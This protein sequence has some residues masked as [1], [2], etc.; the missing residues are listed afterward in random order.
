VPKKIATKNPPKIGGLV[1]FGLLNEK[2]IYNPNPSPS[3]N[4]EETNF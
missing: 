1:A 4:S 2:D 3:A